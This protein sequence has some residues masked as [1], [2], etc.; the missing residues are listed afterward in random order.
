MAE[1]GVARPLQMP[2]PASLAKRVLAKN[3]VFWSDDLGEVPET[4]TPEEIGFELRQI[5]RCDRRPLAFGQGAVIS[6]RS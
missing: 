3:E 1:K 4:A 6:C 5:L 2:F